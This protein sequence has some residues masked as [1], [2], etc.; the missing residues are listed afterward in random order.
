VL[1]KS[2]QLG[3]GPQHTKVVQALR[4]PISNAHLDVPALEEGSLCTTAQ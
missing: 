3:D 4:S 2:K 1:L